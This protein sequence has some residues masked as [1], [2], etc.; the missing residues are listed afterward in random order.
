VQALL[1]CF[2][3]SS[4]GST[5]SSQHPV[6][7]FDIV[8]QRLGLPTGFSIPAGMISLQNIF[9]LTLWDNIFC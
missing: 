8:G 5:G 4:L 9:V 6:C 2:D 3:L 1:F 7:L